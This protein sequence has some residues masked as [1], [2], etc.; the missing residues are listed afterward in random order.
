MNDATRRGLRSLLQVGLVQAAIQFY[1][2]FAST[3]LTADQVTA[4]T[5]LATPLLAF[6]QNLLED[7]TSFPALLKAPASSGQNPAPDDAGPAA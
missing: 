5:V 6:I 7:N 3:Q 4:V 1:N 2:A